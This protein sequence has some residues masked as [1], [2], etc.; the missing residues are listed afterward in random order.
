MFP[1]CTKLK[2]QLHRSQVEKIFREHTLQH[3]D[4]KKKNLQ[5]FVNQIKIIVTYFFIINFILLAKKSKMN[6]NLLVY[7]ERLCF[8]KLHNGIKNTDF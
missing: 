1:I 6:R 5:K 2:F 7:N 4:L 3:I 8:E